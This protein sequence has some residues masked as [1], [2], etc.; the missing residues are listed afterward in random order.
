M[1]SDDDEFSLRFPSYEVP[2]ARFSRTMPGIS[3]IRSG[4]T[5]YEVLLLCCVLSSTQSGE[6]VLM[7]SQGH[8]PLGYN[9]RSLVLGVCSQNM[10][11][12][13]DSDLSRSYSKDPV[14]CH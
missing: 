6:S 8:Y 7:N 9:S 5:R 13:V 12:N 14:Y 1:L 10:Y 11:R 2:V 4:P 3:L